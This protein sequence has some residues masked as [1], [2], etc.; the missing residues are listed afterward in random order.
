LFWMSLNVVGNA[1]WGLFALGGLS[2]SLALIVPWV[3]IGTC[4]ILGIARGKVWAWLFTRWASLLFAILETV[5]LVMTLPALFR[6]AGE[7][8]AIVLL[9]LLLGAVSNGIKYF[10]FFALGSIEA[11]VFFGLMCPQCASRS[12]RP[13]D[14]LVRRIRCRAC[15]HIW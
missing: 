11:R 14:F 8:A 9:L 3:L 13:A 7:N 5:L 4:L 2:N 6:I 12:T 15:H 10:I 1:A